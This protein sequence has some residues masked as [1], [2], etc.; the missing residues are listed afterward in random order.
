MMREDDLGS[1]PEKTL[2]IVVTGSR[3]DLSP[4][5]RLGGIFQE[6]PRGTLG[7]HGARS[8][9][10]LAEGSVEPSVGPQGACSDE[11][12]KPP[13]TATTNPIPTCLVTRRTQVEERKGQGEGGTAPRALGELMTSVKL[14][15]DTGDE[16]PASRH[17]GSSVSPGGFDP[18][19]SFWNMRRCIPVW[20][21]SLLF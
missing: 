9:R 2:G 19:W 21:P 17:Q 1:A 8:S 7:L 11:P 3:S 20:M 16:A 10:R 15:Q 6:Q 13:I 18:G 12:D 4:S 5:F 14:E